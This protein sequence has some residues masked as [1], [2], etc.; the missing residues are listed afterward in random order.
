M[1]RCHIVFVFHPRIESAFE[2][3]FEHGDIPG[4]RRTMQHQVMFMAQFFPKGRSLPQQL[5][6][7]WVV[8]PRACRDE[9]VELR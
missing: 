5:I 6:G 1:E 7:K 8:A 4:F 2:H 3:R 9:A